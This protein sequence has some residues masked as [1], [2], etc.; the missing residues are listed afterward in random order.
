MVQASHK[1]TEFPTGADALEPVASLPVDFLNQDRDPTREIR[2][3]IEELQST[4]R[5]ARRRQRQAEE[6]REQ[7]R[8]K[9]LDAQ[10]RLDS[11]AHNGSQLKALARERDMLIEQQAQYGPTISDLKQRLRQAETEAR[12]AVSERDSAV[13]ERKHAKRQLEEAEIKHAEAFRQRDGALRQREL[14]KDERDKSLERETQAKKNFADAQRAIAET[15]KALAE[16]RQEIVSA[17]RKGDGELAAQLDALRQARDGM[18]AQIKQLT[19]RVGELEDEL[20]EAGYAREA[21]EK[22]ARDSHARLTDIQGVLE[23]TAAGS[24]SQKIGHLEGAILELQSQL[25]AA[26]ARNAKLSESEARLTA[27]MAAM[28]DEMRTSLAGSTDNSA[29][30]EEA[31]ASLVAA[32]RQIE[33]LV[34]ERDTIRGAFTAKSAAHDARIAEQ[35]AEI[36]RLRQELSSNDG[37]LSASNEMEAHFEKRRLDMIELN[38]RLENAHREIRNLS[39]SLAEARLHAKHAGRAMPSATVAAAAKRSAAGREAPQPND[40]IAAMR[41]SFQ[42]LSRDPMQI[43][44]LGE[45]ETH[46]RKLSDQ[47]TDA[48]HPVLQRVCTALASLLGEMIEVPQQITQSSLRTLNQIIELIALLISDPKAGNG[49]R[50]DE[51]RVYVVDDDAD[52]CDSA[53]NAL[54]FAGIQTGRALSS[55]AAIVELASKK[56][57]LIILDVHMPDLNGFE[58]AAQI[59]NMALHAE[60]PI[61]FV[62]GDTSLENR[63]KSSLRGGS[64]FIAKP[65]SIHEI[66]LKAFNALITDQLR[67]R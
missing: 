31:R 51:T 29:L 50:L 43:G 17:K 58:L 16:A 64:E 32:Q 37:K 36:A 63:A 48:G 9:L 23:A 22:Q 41:Q 28:R 27:D 49:I 67:N 34:S 7:M 65:F 46:S 25:A 47:A 30:L 6:E 55:C 12:E 11:G 66:A 33:T 44:L 21:A 39:A 52:S 18:S 26:E 19:Q 24:D 42:S 15:Q 10:D 45:L 5:E 40:A 54:N 4:A 38:T 1:I 57:D 62:T 3:M 35:S 53:V 61:F 2:N 14:F 60:T 59:R 13:R 20:A 56:Y 8:A